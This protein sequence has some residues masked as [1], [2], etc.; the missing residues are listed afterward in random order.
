M[1][2]EDEDRAKTR[3]HKEEERRCSLQNRSQ[4][5]LASSQPLRRSAV[6]GQIFEREFDGGVVALDSG[7]WIPHGDFSEAIVNSADLANGFVLGVERQVGKLTM[8][9]DEVYPDHPRSLPTLHH[10]EKYSLRVS[11][12]G[13]EIS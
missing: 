3:R 9:V 11:A 1:K 10:P 7:F 13:W 8:M 4:S 12:Q 6:P 5:A 2:V